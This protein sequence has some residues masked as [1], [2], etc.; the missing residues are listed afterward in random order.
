MFSWTR[1]KAFLPNSLFSELGTILVWIKKI[2]L[3]SQTSLQ[4]LQ[5]WKWYIALALRGMGSRD[6]S[7]D[8]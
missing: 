2:F 1:V 5:T 7:I 6:N 8:I 4:N 3:V